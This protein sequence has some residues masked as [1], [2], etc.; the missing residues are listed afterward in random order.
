MED[1][2]N[3]LFRFLAL[4]GLVA[5]TGPL[6]YDRFILT[7]P[8]LRA[9]VR[10]RSRSLAIGGAWVI[11]LV[12]LADGLYTGCLVADDGEGIL[13]YLLATRGGRATLV[14]V[15]FGLLA[16][17]AIPRLWPRDSNPSSLL[18]AAP[19]LGALTFSIGAHAVIQGPDAISG[20]FVHTLAGALW[21]G[22][23]VRFALLPWKD[24]SVI[25]AATMAHRFSY[26]GGS[27]VAAL[28]I[29][30]LPAA[31]RNIYGLDALFASHYG[32]ILLIK[33]MLFAGMLVIAAVNLFVIRPRLGRIAVVSGST[34]GGNDATVGL[35]RR[36][37][38]WEAAIAIGLLLA[39]GLLATAPPARDPLGL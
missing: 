3:G 33:L 17:V 6:V 22:G 34:G 31:V 39:A 27:A 25:E 15:L 29:T 4:A 37:V 30:G 24:L 36:L 12:A 23:L 26:F 10:T 9:N 20:N 11:A 16:G 7:D 13:R 38:V 19:P 1:L 18:A 2:I 14:R 5:V 21:I 28:V 35:L 32:R 8:R